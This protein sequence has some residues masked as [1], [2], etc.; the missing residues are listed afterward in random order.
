ME[1]RRI[2]RGP[3]S[4]VRVVPAEAGKGEVDGVVVKVAGVADGVAEG[5]EL[6]GEGAG[7]VVVV[8]D[9]ADVGAVDGPVVVEVGV[10]VV[11]R[12]ADRRAPVV[13]DEA[14]VPAVDDP[15]VVD[16]FMQALRRHAVGREGDALLDVA[17]LDRS[18][19]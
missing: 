12:R 13:R 8:G 9:G 4:G 2:P 6:S 14:D 19:R 18:W 3:P 17:G 16:V 1:L 5:G 7:G 10:G 11:A 15:V